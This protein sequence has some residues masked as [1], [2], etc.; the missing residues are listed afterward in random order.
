MKTS[1]CPSE[2]EEK[3]LLESDRL[4]AVANLQ[5]YQDEKVLE[6]PEGQEKRVQ[7]RQCSLSM[8][9]S[10]RELQ[11]ARVKLGQAIR[12]HGKNKARLRS[13]GPSG[14]EAGALV[15]CK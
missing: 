11:Q 10:H 13:C 9:T 3:D 2:V 8:E 4:K 12:G 6:G 14:T 5:K 1:P 15:V 7:H